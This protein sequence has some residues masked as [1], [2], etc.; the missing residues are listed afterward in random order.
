M[1][2]VG[3]AVKEERLGMGRPFI[4]ASVYCLADLLGKTDDFDEALDLSE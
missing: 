4:V 1:N 3:A 2:P